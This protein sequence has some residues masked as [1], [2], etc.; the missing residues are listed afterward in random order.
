MR[1][2]NA[3]QCV[4][5]LGGILH[6]FS[7]HSLERVTE[8][9]DIDNDMFYISDMQEAISRTM[10]IESPARYTEIMVKR[11]LQDT[12]EFEEPI[13]VIT[14]WKRKKD[15]NLTD[16]FFTALPT[17]VLHQ[18]LDRAREHQHCVILFPLYAVLFAIL[19]K[20]NPTEPTAVVF[21]N[22][23]F[24]DLIVGTRKRVFYANRCVSYDESNE[25]IEALWNTVKA[26][27][28][29]AQNE[30]GIEV[31]RVL[32]LTWP[33]N[34][35]TP[36]WPN[37]VKFPETE[38]I[39]FN[40]ATYDVP[41]LR[42]CTDM[43]ASQGISPPRETA[44]YYANTVAP[45]LNVALAIGIIA[46]IGMTLFYKHDHHLLMEKLEAVQNAKGCIIE[47]VSQE[48]PR[49]P[50]K[51][52]LSFVENVVFSHKAPSFKEVINDI[53]FAISSGM[54]IKVLKLD[55]E[56]ENLKVE[57]F[58]EA[59]TSFDLAHMGYQSFEQ[60]LKEKN[61]LVDESNF[62]TEISSSVFLLKLTKKIQ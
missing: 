60:I 11:K 32:K 46:L 4:I 44:Y 23:R 40:G 21:Q 24:A 10:T 45:Y 58:G 55:Y 26:D 16:I 52:T 19:K 25:A 22:G 2:R 33:G 30:Y 31:T 7:H 61:Y 6:R 8:F 34:H 15:R 20:N 43:V 36:E 18:Y 28:E 62:D 27:I 35:E 3:T 51:D 53:S 59:E 14:H 57:I 12:G 56:R 48:I 9:K 49:V 50:Y 13:S 5:E 1:L 38:K 17:R 41:F 47:E 54:K 42:G 37:D 29:T 39:V